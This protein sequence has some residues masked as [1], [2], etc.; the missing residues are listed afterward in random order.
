MTDVKFR[1]A[2]IGF[3]REAKDF[4]MLYD[5][6]CIAELDIRFEYRYREQLRLGADRSCSRLRSFD[7]LNVE[8]W[9]SV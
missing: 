4:F 3:N 8:I 2:G 6:S 9:N 7:I 5:L 1:E